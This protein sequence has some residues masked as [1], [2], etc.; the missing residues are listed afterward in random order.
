[1]TVWVC[2]INEIY[3]VPYC[4]SVYNGVAVVFKQDLTLSHCRVSCVVVNIQRGS[5][6][7]SLVTF[8]LFYMF[9]K[10]SISQNE[11]CISNNGHKLSSY[12][13]I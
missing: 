9:Q 2:Q 7:K 6:V 10:P 12:R 4:S 5:Y 1:M 3:S 11:T 8:S 13:T